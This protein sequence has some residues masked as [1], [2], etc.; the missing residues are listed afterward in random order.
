MNDAAA[1]WGLAENLA[2]PVS[3][4]LAC[5]LKALDHF[6]NAVDRIETW[7]EQQDALSKGESMTTASIRALIDGT[8]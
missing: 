8:P 5:A 1:M 7:C 2:L 6:G 4:R 3:D